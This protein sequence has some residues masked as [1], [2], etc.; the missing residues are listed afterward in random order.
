MVED[1]AH[2]LFAGRR[3]VDANEI[4]AQRG[5]APG[6]LHEGEVG[7]AQGADHVAVVGMEHGDDDPV[8]LPG[9]HRLDDATQ[10]A[11]ILL[12]VG[13][14]DLVTRGPGRVDDPG[15]QLG[16]E[17]VRQV[18]EDEADHPGPRA[19]TGGRDRRVTQLR[20]DVEDAGAHRFRHP[21]A[22]VEDV[23]DRRRRDA[24]SPGDVGRGDPRRARA[25]PVRSHH[26]RHL[27]P[28]RRC[29]WE[30]TLV[31]PNVVEQR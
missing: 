11:G 16:V 12:G 8:D 26:R 29:G 15:T 3:V 2:E 27:L 21:G 18:G 30:V 22:A 4:G 24:G 31:R 17:G 1:V 20:G 19:T 13:D 5:D 23:G 9:D 6:E 25:L 10:G 14:E 7:A 28:G